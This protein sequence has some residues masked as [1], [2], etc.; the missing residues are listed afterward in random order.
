MSY[1]LQIIV[2]ESINELRS[3]KRKSGVLI[4]K[5]IQML[6]EIKKHEGTALSKRILSELTG[7]NHN[8]IVKWRNVYLKDG[9]EALLVHGRKGGYKE[10]IIKPENRILIE[11]KL[12]DPQNGIRGYVEFQ[13]WIKEEL[14]LDI[15][16]I[17]LH[18]YC[19]RNFGTKIK[20]ARKSH[21]KKDMEAVG[22]F[23]KTS[24][25]DV[26]K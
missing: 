22:I 1:P 4:G 5:R 21:V 8:S 13:K 17:T 15:K 19:T 23:K 12:K 18:K 16:Y 3:L 6:L 11:A 14:T 2:K 26:E 7:I 10:Q 24:H 25:K 20:V 9:I